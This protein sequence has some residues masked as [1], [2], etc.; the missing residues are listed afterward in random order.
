MYL[1]ESA[2]SFLA[3]SLLL[4]RFEQLD[5]KKV[6]F[7]FFFFEKTSYSQ[8]HV[9]NCPK[10]VLLQNLW[11]IVCH[12]SFWVWHYFNATM[13]VFLVVVYCRFLSVHLPMGLNNVLRWSS[14]VL[15]LPI[16]R[17][18]ALDAHSSPHA[19]D[20]TVAHSPLP[21]KFAELAA[22]ARSAWPPKFAEVLTVERS[23]QPPKLT[24]DATRTWPPTIRSIPHLFR[25]QYKVWHPFLLRMLQSFSEVLTGPYF[26]DKFPM[27]QP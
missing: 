24:E 21:R 25:C 1:T 10:F 13:I 9:H 19:E 8:R 12:R 3:D 20:L 5:E 15:P 23:A 27:H 14:L 2:W 26:T 11:K 6:Y 22:V 7:F 17:F 4:V 16:Q 18:D